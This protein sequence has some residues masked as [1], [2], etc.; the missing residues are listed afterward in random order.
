MSLTTCTKC[1][2]I[3]LST[4]AHCP[5]CI[6]QRNPSHTI[7]IALLLGLG[8][9]GCDKLVPEPDTRALY[10]ADIV[11]LDGDGFEEGWDCDDSD[12][13]TYPGAAAQDSEEDCMTDADEDGYG[14]SSPENPNVIAGTDCD[15]SDPDVNPGAGNCE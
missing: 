6:Q 8:L 3:Y 14:D 4:D 12:P 7:P 9:S 11:D 2:T 13:L 1:Q 15:D 10:G 5:E